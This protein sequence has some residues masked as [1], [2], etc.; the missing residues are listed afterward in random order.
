VAIIPPSDIVLDVA[1]AADP[2]RYRLAVERLA[3]LRAT[4]AAA[5]GDAAASSNGPGTSNAASAGAGPP[6]QNRRR[7]DAYGQ[8]EAFVLQSFL[9]VMLPRNASNVYG[10]GTAGEV[11]RSMLAEQLGG[12]LARSGQVGIARALAAGAPPPAPD[13]GSAAA[14]PLGLSAAQ[15]SALSS[16][17]PQAGAEPNAAAPPPSDP[18]RS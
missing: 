9:Q 12:Q 1:R 3:R 13:G 4:A 8:F 15:L 14:P 7:L 18:V 2:E 11:W 16:I 10:R 17:P 6:A 5:G